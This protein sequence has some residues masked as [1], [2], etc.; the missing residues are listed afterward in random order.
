V[1]ALTAGLNDAPSLENPYKIKPVEHTIQYAQ[2]LN[3]D[4]AP[5][6][7]VVVEVKAE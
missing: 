2:D 6:T 3:I 5:Y 4:L 7:V 1:Y